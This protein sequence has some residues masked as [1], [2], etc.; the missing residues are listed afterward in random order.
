MLKLLLLFHWGGGFY[1][2]HLLKYQ[3]GFDII[4][5]PFTYRHCAAQRS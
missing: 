3:G 4:L 1:F 5:R 2:H